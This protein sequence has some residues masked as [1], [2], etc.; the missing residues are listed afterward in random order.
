MG[1]VTRPLP[2][3][4][5]LAGAAIAGLALVAPTHATA[6]GVPEPSPQAPQRA[7]LL[8]QPGHGK[9]VVDALGD[10]LPAAATTNRMSPTALRAVLENDPT[11]WVGEDG[12]LYYVEKAEA[13]SATAGLTAGAATATYPEGDTFA[14]HSLP[15]SNHTIFLDFDGGSVSGTW[16][17]ASGGMPARFYSGFTLDGDPTTFTS[18][19]LA[20]IQQVWRIVAEKYAPFDVDVTTQDPGADGYNR[21]SSLDQTYGDHVMITDDAGAVTSACNNNCS[22]IALVGTFGSTSDNTGYLEPAWVFSSMTSHSAVLTAHTV[23]HEVGHTFGLQHDGVTG[24]ASYYSGQGNWFPIM[25]SGVK[26]VGQFSKGEYA[27]ANNTQDDL[28]VIAANGAPLRVD[29]HADGTMLAEPLATGGVVDGVIGTRSDNDVFAVNHNCASNLTARATGVGAGASLDM[30][31]TVT[32]ALGTVVGAANPTSGQT[33][34]WPA[35]PTG[36]DAQVTVPA[37]VGTYYVRIDGVGNGDAASSG[38]SDYASVGE[39]VLAISACDG[40]MPTVTTPVTPTGVTTT[41]TTT[42]T[43]AG[44]PSTPGIG[45]ASSG[46][47]GGPVTATVRWRSPASNGGAAIVGYRIKA[48]RLARSGR[49]AR[50]LTSALVSSSQQALTLHLPRGHYRFRIVALNPVGASPMSAP[51]RAVIAR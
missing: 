28:A 16:W 21:G 13:L 42:T 39:Y 33:S 6:A 41:T 30:S 36:M 31:V 7:R 22:G 12:Q 46:R 51:S 9:A 45:L 43:H 14:L 49:V 17:N 29:D 8:A 37:G 38:Y 40:T 27:G 48:E 15:G 11:A 25:G 4:L 23:A 32:D 20:Y 26:G 34:S 50:V 1:P 10:K 19:E 35:L 18:A 47:R 24:G 44:L 3:R 2:L 5:A